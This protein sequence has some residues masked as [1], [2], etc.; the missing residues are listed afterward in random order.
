ME[1]HS[2]LLVSN[3]VE[4]D[5]FMACS[6]GHKLLAIDVEG[7]RISR[8]GEATLAVVG[9]QT[10]IRVEVYLFDLLDETAEHYLRQMSA[11][12]SVLEDPSITKIMHDCRQ[13]SDAM[14][15]LFGF[16]IAGVFDTSVCNMFLTGSAGRDSLNNSLSFYG[17]ETNRAREKPNAFH[18][19]NGVIWGNRPLTREQ[20]LCASSDVSS[21]F[22]LHRKM[23]AFIPPDRKAE[24]QL[25]SEKALDEFRSLRWLEDVQ[26]AQERMG[27][28]IGIGG[29]GIESI[30]SLSGATINN[31]FGGGFRIMAKDK[32]GITIAKKMILGRCS[33]KN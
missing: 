31:C 32:M 1:K 24:I 33:L 26:I 9:V 30:R 23:S 21:L 22:D 11:L 16:K 20:I 4:L 3:H 8:T 7:V 15:E 12:K 19:E 10:T 17:C 13:K 27:R 18:A 2:T 6:E 5:E 29:S 28:V 14:N 25:A